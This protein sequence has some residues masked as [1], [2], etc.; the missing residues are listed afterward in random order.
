M[1]ILS[2][3]PTS[4]SRFLD[5]IARKALEKSSALHSHT[6]S[7]YWKVSYRPFIYLYL[8]K[9][10]SRTTSRVQCRAMLPY[11]NEQKIK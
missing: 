8:S 2:P 9:S 11:T 6:I 1:L 3:T 5:K 4:S 10:S 7:T